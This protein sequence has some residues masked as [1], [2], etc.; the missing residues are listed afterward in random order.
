MIKITT[1]AWFRYPFFSAS[2]T[3]R[4]PTPAGIPE[5]CRT[6]GD[7]IR[8]ARIERGEY[9]TDLAK[10][11][12]VTPDTV[13]CWELNRNKV[14]RINYPVI[15]RYLGYLPEEYELTELAYK[16]VYYRWKHDLSMQRLAKIIG[17]DYTC[18]QSAEHGKEN[19]QKRT[20]NRITTFFNITKV[21]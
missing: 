2:L 19:F 14:G 10:L 17:V 5:E 15:K 18:I 1:G 7:H 20:L 6:L 8:K 11:F 4:R 16:L 9:Q 21:V 13:T 3:A 12:R